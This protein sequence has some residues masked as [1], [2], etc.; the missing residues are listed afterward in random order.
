M[1][2]PVIEKVPHPKSKSPVFIGLVTI[3]VIDVLEI[4]EPAETSRD[5]LLA[6]IITPDLKMHTVDM[7]DSNISLEF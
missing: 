6:L 2:D 4:P 5:V 7:T 1:D 3:H